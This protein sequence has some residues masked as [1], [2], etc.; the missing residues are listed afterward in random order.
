M[1]K[2]FVQFRCSIY[3]KKLLRVKAHKCGLSISEYC[4]RAAFEDRIIER[5]TPEQIEIYKTLNRYEVNFKR[6]GNMYRKRNPKLAD[7]VVILANEIRT[8]LLSFKK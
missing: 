4:R 3:E 5:F 8:H 6:I 2:E 1:K 7:E